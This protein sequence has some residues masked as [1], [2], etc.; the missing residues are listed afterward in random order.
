MKPI[1]DIRLANLETLIREAGTAESLAER[2]G[3]SSVYI[4]QIRSRSIDAK[5]GRP[6]NLGSAAA[7]KM[8]GGMG[9][10]EGWMDRDH[11]DADARGDQ[12][13]FR[14]ISRAAYLRLTD[15][16]QEAIEDWVVAQVLAFSAPAPVKSDPLRTANE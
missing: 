6:R 11:A 12:W 13:P 10:P 15:A 9:K 16:Q 5:T 4:S 8:E 3:L 7:R 14:K 1:A 2:S